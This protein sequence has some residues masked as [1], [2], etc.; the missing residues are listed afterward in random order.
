[1]I[2]LINLTLMRGTTVLIDNANTTIY[3]KYKVGIIGRNGCGK[4]SLFAAIKGELASEKGSIQVPKGLKISSVSQKTPA[5]IQSAIEYVIDGD[6]DLREL[7]RQRQKAEEEGNGEK[8]AILED[9]LGIAG[10]WDIKAR[11]SALLHGL[12]FSQD[13]LSKSVK[14]FSGGWRMRL[15]LAQALIYKSDLLLLDEPTNHLDLDTIIFLENYLK[16][17]QG[18]LLCISHDRDF[19]DSFTS[20]ILHFEQGSVVMYTGN[21]SDYERL[22]AERIKAEKAQRKR[23]EAIIAHMQSFVDRFRYKAT[24]AKQ[25]QSMIKAINYIL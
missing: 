2:S 7:Q 11:A 5:L 8:I 19:L 20:H 13:E 25:A 22:R 21:Y 6:K 4:S 1:M 9:K 3:P 14:D 18:T 10:A 12:G 23:E 15:N 17:Y 24:K 16:N